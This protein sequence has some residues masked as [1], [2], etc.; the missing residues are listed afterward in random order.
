MI[1]SIS[2]YDLRTRILTDKGLR[3]NINIFHIRLFQE[4]QMP[5]SLQKM[6]KKNH[7][8]AKQ[9]FPRNFVLT[10]FFILS[11][12]MWDFQKKQMGG[13]LGTLVSAGRT[14]ARTGKY[15][16]TRPFRLNPGPN[17]FFRNIITLSKMSCFYVVF[18][19]FNLLA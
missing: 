1:E 8:R 12:I 7:F 19:A 15:K 14:Q 4:K 2:A 11:I 10:G 5:E 6:Q 3:W 9:N 13:F 18:Y 16:F 17:K